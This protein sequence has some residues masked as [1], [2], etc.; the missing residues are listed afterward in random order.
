MSQVN[1]A[2][3]EKAV[4]RN[5]TNGDGEAYDGGGGG[6]ISISIVTAFFQT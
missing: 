4:S 6:C 3:G 2:E 5:D 1:Y